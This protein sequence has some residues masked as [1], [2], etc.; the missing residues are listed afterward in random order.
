[1]S[2][3]DDDG[4][5]KTGSGAAGAAAVA[6][7]PARVV[8]VTS[9]VGG[10]EGDDDEVTEPDGDVLVAAG[11]QVG[12]AGLEGLDPPDL[13]R[14]VVGQRIP[15]AHNTRSATTAKAAATST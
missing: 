13:D 1:L 3:L 9:Q 10:L 6:V 5:A 2:L 8:P 15:A 11:A 4:R 14:F 12:L 7:L